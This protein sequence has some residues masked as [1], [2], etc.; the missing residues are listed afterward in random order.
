MGIPSFVDSAFITP[1]DFA[2]KQGVAHIQAGVGGSKSN[3]C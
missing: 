1:M 3:Q 2:S